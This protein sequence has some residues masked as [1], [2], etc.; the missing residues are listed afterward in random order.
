MIAVPVRVGGKSVG[1]LEVF[2]A[3]PNAFS[4]SESRVLQRLAE[5]VLAA[6]N[7]AARAENLPALEAPPEAVDFAPTPGSVLFASAPDQDKNPESK[8][9]GG[10]TRP[11]AAAVFLSFSSNRYAPIP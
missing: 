5:T 11:P 2:S 8:S 7:R 3:Q 9:N 6:L 1:I 4:E 10:D